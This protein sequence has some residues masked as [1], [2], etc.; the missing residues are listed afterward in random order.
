MAITQIFPSSPLASSYTISVLIPTDYSVGPPGPDNVGTSSNSPYSS[1]T[2]APTGTPNNYGFATS[3]A[4][5]PGTGTPGYWKN[6]PEAWPSFTTITVGGVPYTKD[7]ALA[8]LGKVTKDRTT[9]AICA[10]LL[11]AMLNVMIGNDKSCIQSTIDAANSSIMRN[12]RQ[13]GSGVSGGSAAWLSGDPIH[14][15]LDAYNNGLLCA[16][17]RK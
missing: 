6:H 7:Q 14:N 11:P 17:H 16:P 4:A 3:A 12:T 15:T 9:G 1:V 5:N 10:A 2:V 8:A 13:V